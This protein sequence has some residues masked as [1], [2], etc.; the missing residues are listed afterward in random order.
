MYENFGFKPICPLGGD[1]IFDKDKGSVRNSIYGSSTGSMKLNFSSN[2]I[3]QQ[4][5]KNLFET[6]ELRVEFKLTSEGIMT[7]I[8]DKK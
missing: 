3:V 8:I 5:I 6:S 4:Y 1:Y 2:G 7:K